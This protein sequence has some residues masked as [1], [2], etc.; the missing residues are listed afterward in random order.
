MYKNDFLITLF[1]NSVKPVG[2]ESWMKRNPAIFDSQDFTIPCTST[3]W[4]G[5]TGVFKR[6]QWKNNY[7]FIF[8]KLNFKSY[9]KKLN[10]KGC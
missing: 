6:N 4:L 1:G 7:Y 2:A 10:I 3:T 9:K 5:Y 8:Y